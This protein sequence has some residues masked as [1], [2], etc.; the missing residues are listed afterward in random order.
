M[1]EIGDKLQI[2]KN[3]RNI[4]KNLFLNNDHNIYQDCGVD[5]NHVNLK[6]ILVKTYSDHYIVRVFGGKQHYSLLKG[7]FNKVK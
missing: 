4:L 6:F 2:K 5:P 1:I 3:K 7:V